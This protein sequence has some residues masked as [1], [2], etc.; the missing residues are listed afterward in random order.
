ML[1]LVPEERLWSDAS[2]G[3]GAEHRLDERRL[4]PLLYALLDR[5]A[6][7]KRI[8]L[9]LFAVE[10]R[11]VEEVAALMGATQTA[12]RSRVFFA[13]RE[14]R[15]LIAADPRLCALAEAM[16]GGVTGQDGAAS[17]AKPPGGGGRKEGGR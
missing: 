16:L 5:I 13:R 6:A 9:L 10:G 3:R 12:T 2:H 8:A 15:A 7:P 14:L 4:G 1:E 11:P 17:V